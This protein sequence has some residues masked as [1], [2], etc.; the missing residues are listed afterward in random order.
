MTQICHLLKAVGV[1]ALGC[2]LLAPVS[3]RHGRSVPG[4]VGVPSPLHKMPAA[5]NEKNPP[6]TVNLPETGPLRLTVQEAVLTALENN[7][8]LVVER[9]HPAVVGTFDQE[10]R[11]AFDPTFEAAASAQK[12]DAQGPFAATGGRSD[13]RSEV[14]LADFRLTE[15]FPTGTLVEASATAQTTDSTRYADPFASTRL[16]LSVTQPLLQGYGV[17]VNLARLHQSRLETA[18]SRYELRGFSEFLVEQVEEAYW[19]YALAGRQMEIVEES[20]S[21]VKQ[22]LSETEKTIRVGTMAESELAAVQAELA[23]QQQGII[24]ARSALETRRLRLLR[25]LNPPG[26]DLWNRKIILVHPPKVP[27]VHF[28]QVAEHARIALGRRPEIRQAQLQM[29][30][31]DLE[32]VR[33]RNGLLPRLDLFVT[34][35]KTGYAD[36][37]GESAGNLGQD[38]YDAAGGLRLAYPLGNRQAAA[39]HTRA[40]LQREQVEKALDNLRQLVELDVRNAYLEVRR[41]R[42]QI[43]ASRATRKLQ[44]EKHRIETEKFRVGRSTSFLVAQAQRDLLASR[45]GEVQAVVSYLR[46]LTAFYRLE[47]TLLERRGLVTPGE[48]AGGGTVSR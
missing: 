41:T 27:E 23:T 43:D 10:E 24:N 37:F 20:L 39:R 44:E 48:E 22:Q 13:E 8:A 16:G 26:N 40:L 38:D 18:I 1:L 17:N 7:R 5:V 9:I 45:I 30:R 6:G 25:L 35:G 46:A 4:A 15:F 36:S 42:Q 34:L 47:G 12:E 14:L 32:I 21:L 19:D 33:T 11:A 31:Q 3:C 29:Q 28:D 2:L